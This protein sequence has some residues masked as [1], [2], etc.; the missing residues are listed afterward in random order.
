[1][2]PSL[3]EIVRPAPSTKLSMIKNKQH[4]FIRVAFTYKNLDF[5]L[6]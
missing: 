3:M 2:D 4:F 6:L 5:T 1:M